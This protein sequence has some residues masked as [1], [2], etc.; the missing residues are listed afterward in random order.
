MSALG[1][2]YDPLRPG[3][4][5]AALQAV[6]MRSKS[7][8]GRTGGP[9]S[10][11]LLS[12]RTLRRIIQ[13]DR[14]WSGLGTRIP[15]RKSYVI[16]R[17]RLLALVRE[18]EVHEEYYP[19]LSPLAVVLPRA[20]PERLATAPSGQILSEHWRLIF[21]AQL[22]IALDHLQAEGKL[23]SVDIRNRIHQ[24]GQAEFDEA[25][26][27]L[28]QENYLLPPIDSFS[29]YSEFASVYLELETFNPRL[30]SSYF[31]GLRDAR[32]VNAV[33]AL[34]LDKE[35]LLERTRPPGAPEPVQ[36]VPV[37]AGRRCQHMLLAANDAAVIGNDVRTTQLLTQVSHL[38]ESPYADALRTRAEAYLARL[39][40]RLAPA[41]HLDE[42]GIQAWNTALAPLMEP[43]ARGAWGTTIRFLYDLQK[44]GVDHSKGVYAV[45]LG[46][47]I[48]TLG[49]RPLRRELPYQRDVLVLKHLRKAT[50]R[51]AGV[52]VREEERAAISGLLRTATD[53]KER[54]LRESCRK[55]VEDVL[56][57]VGFSATNY[58][59][60]VARHKVVAEFLDGI[61]SRGY[62]TMSDL[63]DIISANQLKLPDIAGLADYYRG[64]R[65]LA[66]DALLQDR[67]DGIYHPGE[68][69]LRFL[70]QAS[71][72]AFGTEFGRF[73]S[74]YIALPLLGSVVSVLSVEEVL[75]KVLGL[76]LPE[77]GTATYLLL[78][79]FIGCL[80][81]LPRFRRGVVSFFK[82]LWH[83]I[84][85]VVVRVPALILQL[86]PIAT[87]LKSRFYQ[88]LRRRLVKLVVIS[89]VAYAIA[90]GRGITGNALGMCVVGSLVLTELFLRSRWGEQ[91]ED[92]IAD[93]F[94][95]GWTWVSA[96]I[97]PGL[98]RFVTDLFHRFLEAVERFLYAV[99]TWLRFRTG[100]SNVTLAVKAVVGL[101]WG[102]LAY[103]LRFCVNLLIE[104]QINPIKHFPVVTVSHKM[105]LPMVPHLANI[106]HATFAIDIIAARSAA[107]TFLGSIPGIFGFLVWELKA[108]WYL[109]AA[110]RTRV[111]S[112]LAIGSHG[113]TMLRLMKP[114]FHSGTLPKLYARLRQAEVDGDKAKVH[115]QREGLHH[116]G[117]A[118]RNVVEREL[119]QLLRDS[120]GWGLKNLSLAGMELDSNRIAVRLACPEA[121]PEPLVLLFEEQ[122]GRVLAS[123][124]ARGWL[125]GV[126]PRQVRTFAAA[127][128]GFYQLMGVN[129]TRER[130]AAAL[131]GLPYDLTEGGLVVWPVPNEPTAIL[132]DLEGIS[133]LPTRVLEGQ[134]VP[135]PS[136]LGRD[137]FL[138]PEGVPWERWVAFWDEDAAG[139][140]PTLTFGDGCAVL[141][142][143]SG[144]RAKQNDQ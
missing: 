141:P 98:F 4:L 116:V 127:L 34:D 136:L 8:D 100:E 50:G 107:F 7:G 112:P 124:P 1:G 65:L 46:G 76:H 70:Q 44:V 6:S 94:A 3:A 123:I 105:L 33:L 32:A 52:R 86:E 64:N 75:G 57:S 68:I 16:S 21:H 63:R 131:S 134:R 13:V 129:M 89:G 17:E 58:P 60:R 121:G 20:D 110:N 26:R 111:L 55:P 84:H 39:V 144:V 35:A 133:E 113:E 114:G 101:L 9:F 30:L 61:T 15:H 38:V 40:Q 53:E 138:T 79:V 5:E 48:L 130:L 27:V 25:T 14:E 36:L 103:I 99:D 66:A 73:F 18:G 49:R 10:V 56:D 69:Y 128:L 81:H 125:P 78:A 43:A 119:I 47:W 118:I 104:P 142:E 96:D 77:M 37:A 41:L 72:L 54:R 71:A 31:P 24:L 12:K 102:I 42:K 122:S 82:G 120:P 126:S 62:A 29:I 28:T 51:L 106:I 11:V 22:H 93:S 88:E 139:A 95:Y 67:L 19:D 90:E 108:N 137:I 143:A 140:E 45:D 91:L 87:I 97:L 109:Y 2:A 23:T 83:L 59:E 74:S 92:Y 117:I 80:V 132:Y 135:V 115:T 85:F